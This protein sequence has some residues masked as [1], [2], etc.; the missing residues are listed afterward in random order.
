MDGEDNQG[1]IGVFLEEMITLLAGRIIGTVILSTFP[2]SGCTSATPLVV[3]AAPCTG[4]T[5]T[6]TAAALT[7]SG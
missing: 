5:T 4:T 7:T 6:T 3:L 2:G 1:R